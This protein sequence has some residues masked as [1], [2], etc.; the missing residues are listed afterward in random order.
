[1]KSSR[2]K[3]QKERAASLCKK[4][5]KGVDRCL[6]K[7]V[8]I[9][10]CGNTATVMKAERIENGQIVGHYAVKCVS[11]DFL[12]GKGNQLAE[13]R[14]Y[15]IERERKVMTL[16]DNPHIVKFIEPLKSSRTPNGSI[17]CRN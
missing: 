16:L 8:S 15:V 12:N 5:L 2:Q 14:W 6:L 3:Y 9:I 10:D 13:R 11:K 4:I 7:M 1:M 17:S